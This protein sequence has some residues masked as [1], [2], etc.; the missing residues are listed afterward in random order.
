MT[1]VDLLC[2]KVLEFLQKSHEK[3]PEIM[4]IHPE[5][6][7]DITREYA[8]HRASTETIESL[9]KME[10]RIYNT[11]LQAYRSYDVKEKEII[12]M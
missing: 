5:T 7:V 9:M 4:I 1:I 10:I 11:K 8:L 3:K 6:W 12:V 2:Q